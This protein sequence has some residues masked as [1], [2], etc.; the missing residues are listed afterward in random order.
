M[1]LEGKTLFVLQSQ[2]GG[3]SGQERAKR[4]N[5]NLREF[6]DNQSLSLD[7]LEIYTRAFQVGDRIKIGDISGKVL[8]TTLLVTRILT[9]TKVVISLYLIKLSYLLI[10]AE[11]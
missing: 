11:S 6:A 7:E 5:Q 4:M 8:E 1:Q 3:L 10:R 2:L 9:P